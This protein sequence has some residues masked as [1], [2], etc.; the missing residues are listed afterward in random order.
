MLKAGS[1]R[2]RPVAEVKA[3]KQSKFHQDAAL[4]SKF[5]ELKAFELHIDRKKEEL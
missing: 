1:K 2:R 4:Q 3:E 5:D